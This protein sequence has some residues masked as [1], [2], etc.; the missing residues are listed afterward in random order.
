MAA[1]RAESE[2]LGVPTQSE[3]RP[4]MRSIAHDEPALPEF[5]RVLEGI[6]LA[7]GR[8]AA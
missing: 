1:F 2:R 4:R 7:R 5:A 3:S 8:I 6:A